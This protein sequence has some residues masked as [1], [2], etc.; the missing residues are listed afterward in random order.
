MVTY[1]RRPRSLWGNLSLVILQPSVFYRSFPLARHW[2][3]VAVL[4]LTLNGFSAVNQPTP[5]DATTG[6]GTAVAQPPQFSD[7]GVTPGSFDGGFIPPTDAGVLPGGAATSPN[8]SKTVMTA[9]LAAGGVVLAWFIQSIILSEVSLINGARPSFGRNWQIAVWASVPLGLMLL[10]QQIYYAVGGEPGKIGLSLL[11]EQWSG[12]AA[13][14]AFS[15]AVLTT[16]LTNLTLFWLWSLLLLYLGGRYVLNGKRA[17]V[18]LVIVA[19]VIISVFV[20][21][22]TSP[23]AADDVPVVSDESSMGIVP[24][25]SLVISPL[26]TVGAAG[27]AFE[28]SPSPTD[29]AEA[30]EVT[31]AADLSANTALEATAI[32]SGNTRGTS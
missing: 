6:D 9:L 20:P 32:P 16:L 22:L 17:A 15:R 7:S 25:D 24:G 2:L 31:Q 18:M 4:I 30:S 14:P 26:E 29:E 28:L 19:W 12:F 21:A 5:G 11:L 23:G 10:I 27:D 13:L 8:V 3:W 1:S